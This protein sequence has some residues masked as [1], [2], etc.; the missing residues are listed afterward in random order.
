MTSTQPL[1]KSMPMSTCG[2]LAIRFYGD[3]GRCYAAKLSLD[4]EV[5]L[6]NLLL[7]NRSA[8]L[9]DSII[10][11]KEW[12][13]SGIGVALVAATWKYGAAL[14][15]SLSKMRARTSKV[16]WR[17]ATHLP[18]HWTGKT[19]EEH[20][21]GAKP[22]VYSVT[23]QFTVD[24]SK[25]SAKSTS[26]FESDGSTRSVTYDLAGEFVSDQFIR[27]EYRNTDVSNLNFGT[28]VIQL[29][30]SGSSFSGW[31]VGFNS[32][33]GGIIAGKIVG[34]KNPTPPHTSEA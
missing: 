29:D 33:R 25:V 19:Q 20:F 9:L 26:T 8:I 23:W 32:K 27:L 18:G 13:F 28:E 14:L 2:H 15:G 22:I 10:Q 1:E 3:R 34:E 6:R 5:R 24:G 7:L 31:F 12:V 21:V 17:G 4:K 16:H 11:A 30:Y